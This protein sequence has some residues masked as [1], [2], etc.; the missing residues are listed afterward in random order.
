VHVSLD[1]PLL[2]AAGLVV[3]ALI[4]AG[5]Y[6]HERLN[7]RLA[8]GG[9]LWLALTLGYLRSGDLP[10]LLNRLPTDPLARA[11]VQAYDTV[12]WL[13]L[14]WL[15]VAVLNLLLWRWLFPGSHQPGGRKLVADLVSGL[16]Y[17]AAF[18]AILAFAFDQ[19][20]SGVL[21]TS[22]V[23]AIVL[24]LALQTSLG[25]IVSGLFMSVEAPYRA[26]DWVTIDDKI[27]GR[28]LETN[29]RATRIQTH[30][31]DILIVPNST[32]ARAQ[33][34]NHYFPS[35]QHATSIEVTID[36][37]S[38][39]DRVLSVL[40]AAVL[41]TPGIHRA[42]APR[43]IVREFGQTAII[44]RVTFVVE[45]FA[46]APAIRSDVALRIWHHLAW[47]GIQLE[48]PP[49]PAAGS[50][51]TEAERRAALERALGRIS[52]FSPLTAEERADLAG[53]FRFQKVKLGDT[54]VQEGAQ[55]DSLFLV[56]EGALAVQRCREDGTATDVNSLGPGD[57]F[58]EMSLLTGAPR[59][60]SVVTLTDACVHELAKADLAPVLNARPSLARELAGVVAARER[61]LAEAGRAP[62]RPS[63]TEE[64]YAERIAG[65][66]ISFFRSGA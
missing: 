41:A 24:G 60:A 58:G 21:A 8:W 66:I 11:A 27:E 59:S 43:V 4:I 63:E 3:L 14:A 19:D 36:A 62:V 65:W 6:A 38:A 47:A 22:G 57:Y 20:I 10:M 9:A 13:S 52:L 2:A 42:A 53:R 1:T 29:W 45:D 18:F 40:T 49:R 26:G 7:R 17:I 50:A 23:V 51:E 28:V 5:F 32:V 34:V 54:I 12:W 16:V 48:G 61:G 55:G 39:P 44:Y 30:T 25:E 33:I 46:D 15:A 35:R 56:S 31:G 64:S 37:R